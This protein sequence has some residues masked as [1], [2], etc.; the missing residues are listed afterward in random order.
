LNVITDTTPRSPAPAQHHNGI[1]HLH[2]LCRHTHG[3]PHDH[4]NKGITGHRHG[5]HPQNQ[6]ACQTQ[7]TAPEN[8][9]GQNQARCHSQRHEKERQDFG[10]NNHITCPDLSSI[11]DT[12]S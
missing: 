5:S 9:A 6:D 7:K 4:A 11:I 8:N 2:I 12:E 10:G 1:S 3:M